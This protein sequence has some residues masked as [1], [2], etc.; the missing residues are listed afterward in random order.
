[1]N[2][3]IANVT[4]RRKLD[5]ILRSVSRLRPLPSNTTRILNALGD[6]HAT[7]GIIAELVS[8][9]QAITAYVLRVANS[10]SLGYLLSCSSV[11]DAVV[12]LGFKQVRSLVMS[13]VVAG[14]L[15]ARL[16][17]Y[18]LGDKELW[19]HSI[20]VA[21]A[22]HW[23]ATCFHYPDPEKAYVAGLLHDIGKLVLDQFVLADYNQIVSL[24]QTR[25]MPMWKIEEEL[26][27]ID[28]AGVGGLASTQWQFPTELTDAIRNH[29]N[30]SLELPDQRLAA[31][32]NL[33]NALIPENTNHMSELEGR[34]IHPDALEILKLNPAAVEPTRE[35]L[36]EALFSYQD[37]QAIL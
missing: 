30:P 26:F 15:T 2:D 20:A 12:R 22:A 31:L 4:T 35:K 17:G 28:H 5:E 25:Q 34:V 9:D 16:A 37:R 23:L 21:C 27:G 11:K 14:P 32:V 7:A 8:L 1:M 29:H 13:T 3:K 36:A 10:V 19:Y 6:P 18:R 33:A 24:M